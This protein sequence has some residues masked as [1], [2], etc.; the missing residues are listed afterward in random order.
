FWIYFDSEDFLCQCSKFLR[1]HRI[2][3]VKIRC[4]FLELLDSY[5]SAYTHILGYF[6]RICAPGSYHSRARSYEIIGESLLRKLFGISKEPIEFSRIFRREF[7][8]SLHTVNG[9]A[10]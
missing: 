2:K 5:N 6:Y 4:Y 9:T 7:L 1:N 10:G 3:F 8:L